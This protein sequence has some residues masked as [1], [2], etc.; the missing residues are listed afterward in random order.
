MFSAGESSETLLEMGGEDYALKKLQRW[1]AEGPTK[2]NTQMARFLLNEG[3][4]DSHWSPLIDLALKWGDFAMWQEILKKST[5]SRGAPNLSSD[6][7]I[8]AWSTFTFDRT[9]N[10]FVP[11]TFTSIPNFV[12]RI[13]PPFNALCRI[14]QVICDQSSTRAAVELINTLR[15]RFPPQHP[16][17]VAWWKRQTTRAL[18]TINPPPSADD[19]QMFIGIAKSEGIFFFSQTC[20]L[21]CADGTDS[22]N[23]RIS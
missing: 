11:F 5:R 23:R 14:K 20:V 9:K 19:I 8:R 7:L 2:R 22:L 16:D 18:S 4:S 21:S 10:M 15:A 13:S 6:V 17:M 12:A 1:K 3:Y